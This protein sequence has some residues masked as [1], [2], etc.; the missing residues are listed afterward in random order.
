ML[1]KNTADSSL[2]LGNRKEIGL[3]NYVGGSQKNWMIMGRRE[4][5]EREIEDGP[6]MLV[7]ERPA[8]VSLMKLG[9]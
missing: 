3:K 2:Y 5:G 7:G 6:K 9:T 8:M 4:K 1:K